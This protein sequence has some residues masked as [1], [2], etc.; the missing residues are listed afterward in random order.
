M[1]G[2]ALT[3]LDMVIWGIVATS[4]MVSIMAA[5][6]SFGWSRLSMSFLL[7]TAFTADRRAANV[8]GFVLYIV[9]GWLIAFFYYLFF[10]VLGRAG[11]ML[12][13]IVGGVHGILLLTIV[14]PLL[15]SMHPRVA[16]EYDGPTMQ[17]PMEPPGFLALHYG[18]RTPAVTLIAHAVYGG[19]LG[20]GFTPE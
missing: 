11:W 1:S 9:G 2:V 4:A 18:Y 17:R 15:P 16:S 5:S 7:G 20:V 3:L 10:A 8:L 19:I 13:A 14:M 6:Q 12:G